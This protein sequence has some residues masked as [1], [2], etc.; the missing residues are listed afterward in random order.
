MPDVGH[1]LRMCKTKT[2]FDRFYPFSRDFTFF[3]SFFS[4]NSTPRQNIVIFNI[5]GNRKCTENRAF[6]LHQVVRA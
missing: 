2:L 1:Y 5:T 3:F 6:F 4:L